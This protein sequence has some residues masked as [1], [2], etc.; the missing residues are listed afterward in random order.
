MTFE[1]DG[2]KYEKASTHQKEWGTRLISELKLT[3]NERILDLGCGDGSL[4]ETLAHLV[5]DGNV[6]GIDASKGMIDVARNRTGSNLRFELHDI[7]TMDLPEKFDI[8]ISNAT[9]HWIKDHQKLW[10]NIK[11]ILSE[12]AIVRFNF[13]AHGNCSHFYK[14]I[15]EAI[16]LDD[17]QTYFSDFEWPWY[18]P[19]VDEYREIINMQTFSEIKVWG[20]NADRTFP[21]KK[22][23]IGWI[24]QPSIVPFLKYIPEEKKE[25]FRS[26]V[27]KQMLI[28][29][30]RPDG[31]YFETFRRIN[32]FAQN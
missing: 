22:S 23:I 19:E 21:D 12:N 6:L 10:V 11:N 13:A 18:M 9:L 25:K 28:D 1:F 8:I 15:R 29:T 20:E 24:N 27:I 31:G 32:I 2:A 14:I 26:Y 5:P 7:N 17:Y 30:A 3:G 16:A 4:T